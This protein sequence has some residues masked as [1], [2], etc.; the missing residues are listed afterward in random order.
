MLG[1]SR[2]TA[3]RNGWGGIYQ[4]GVPLVSGRCSM[5]TF[6][7]FSEASGGDPG[8]LGGYTGQPKWTPSLRSSISSNGEISPPFSAGYNYGYIFAP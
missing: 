4:G 5:A 1:D 8:G 6:L 2:P 7:P 3:F